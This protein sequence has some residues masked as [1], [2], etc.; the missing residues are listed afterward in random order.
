MT[1]TPDDPRGWLHVWPDVA[2]LVA[3]VLAVIIR[4]SN[5][6]GPRSWRVVLAD[7]GATMALGYAGYRGAIGLD[8]DADLA[9]LI[10]V[11]GA[12][13]GWEFV[14]RIFGAWANKRV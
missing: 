6:D 9:F 13:M 7:A 14:R 1:P 10:A 8:L 3:G 11:L 2:A 12:A 4:T 5:S